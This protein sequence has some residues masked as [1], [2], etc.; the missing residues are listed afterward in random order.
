VRLLM[1]PVLG[2]LFLLGGCDKQSSPTP[3]PKAEVKPA[4]APSP[5][6]TPATPLPNAEVMGVLDRTHKG[7]AVP[8]A[9]FTGPR[10]ET[11]RLVTFKGKPLLVNLWATWCGPCVAEMPTLDTLAARRIAD[12]Q[13]IVVSQDMQGKPLVDPWWAKRTFKMLKPYVDAKSDLSVAYGGGSLPT[14]VLYDAAG[15]EVW[16][17]VGATDWESKEA[18]ALLGEAATLN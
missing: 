17:I 3:Q 7:E 15:K 2:S 13:I 8:G 5:L 18:D 1:V 6:P 12:L 11:T 16:R 9:V 10:G 14:T 4:P